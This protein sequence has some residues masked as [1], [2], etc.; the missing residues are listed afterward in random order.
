[1]DWLNPPSSH[2]V[3]FNWLDTAQSWKNLSN[4]LSPCLEKVNIDGGNMENSAHHDARSSDCSSLNTSGQHILVKK[5]GWKEVREVFIIDGQRFSQ[6]ERQPAW[7]S[8][9][10]TMGQNRKK[11]RIN[12]HPIN[13][14][15]TSEGVSEVSERA[16]E[17]AQRR[18]RAKRAVP[19]KRTSERCE[20]T[21]ERTSEWPST[22]VSILVCSRPQW[23]ARVKTQV[24][25]AFS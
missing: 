8:S 22:Y 24:A 21:S 12:S 19:S 13:P 20:R 25:N 3:S 1:M 10:H 16:N 6:R 18:A 17:W 15:P 2:W 14:C 7:S 23:I 5:N 11:H 4:D 9:Q